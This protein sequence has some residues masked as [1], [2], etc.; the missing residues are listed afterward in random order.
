[1]DCL[2][3]LSLTTAINFSRFGGGWGTRRFDVCNWGGG[4]GK[5]TRGQRRPGKGTVSRFYISNHCHNSSTTLSDQW[6]DDK[7]ISPQ[8]KKFC[9]DK[10][11]LGH[12]PFLW[13]LILSDM[14]LV[15]PWAQ[16]VP[17]YWG[18]C[19]FRLTL[20]KFPLSGTDLQS[21]SLGMCL[22]SRY[23]WGRRVFL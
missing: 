12:F 21:S 4:W 15:V 18:M 10:R 7:A 9:T 23:K 20:L 17:Q 14:A 2:L 16:Q 6:H 11:L 13:M 5:W 8:S 22:G 3:A 1:M 19:W